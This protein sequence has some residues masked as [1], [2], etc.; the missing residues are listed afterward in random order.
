MSEPQETGSNFTSDKP[1]A[2]GRS[3]A[4]I[5]WLMVLGSGALLVSLLL[6]GTR[7][8]Q[9][10]MHRSQC[11]NNLKQI[12]LALYNYEEHYLALPPAYTV[13]THGKPLHSFVNTTKQKN[14]TGSWACNCEDFKDKEKSTQRTQYFITAAE[15][16]NVL[17][18]PS[19]GSDI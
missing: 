14:K 1:Q 16:Q 9:P 13:D 8:P 12:A 6:P 10:P 18:E 5:T 2:T 15:R 17:T 3:R 11:V 7:T 4:W 19:E